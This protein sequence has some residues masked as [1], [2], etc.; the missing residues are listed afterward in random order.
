MLI[1]LGL[2]TTIALFARGPAAGRLRNAGVPAWL[3][4][5]RVSGRGLPISAA[6]KA[7]ALALAV[8]L[9]QPGPSGTL[10][11]LSSAAAAPPP[12]AE[13]CRPGAG[14]CPPAVV[15]PSQFGYYATN[16]RKWPGPV[17]VPVSV[18]NGATPALP[19]KSMIPGVDQES[20]PQTQPPAGG[21]V[22]GPAPVA[23]PQVIRLPEP[24]AAA[25]QGPAAPAAEAARGPSQEQRQEYT[26]ESV[27]GP[28]S[29][30]S[31]VSPRPAAEQP[32][33]GPVAR[34]APP[35]DAPPA[36][37]T[38]SPTAPPATAGIVPGPLPAPL[39]GPVPRQIPIVTPPAASASTGTEPAKAD[40]YASLPMVVMPG[41]SPALEKPVA[42]PAASVSTGFAAAW[43]DAQ[44]RIAEGKAADALQRLS[45]WRDD[46]TLDAEQRQRLDRQLQRLAGTVIYSQQDLLLPPHVVVPDET[47]PQI[48]GKLGVSWQFLAR[49]N[50]ITDPMRLIPGESIKIVRGPFD[51]VLSLSRGRLSLQL[52]GSYAGEFPV[53]VGSRFES[54]VG[55]VLPVVEVRRGGAA[56]TPT[57]RPARG[58]VLAEDLVI[59][60]GETTGPASAGQSGSLIVSSRDL[61]ELIDILG[62]GSMVLVRP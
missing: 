55:R 2:I 35:A 34:P 32:A 51:A 28:A 18:R 6:T 11:L 42:P 14:G 62:P 3:R 49:I 23:P 21:G 25:A 27:G 24:P 44:D 47:L 57:A 9:V 45:A 46:P 4:A 41:V 1:I 7:V 12:P 59:E 58:L 33:P 16:W 48:A 29:D 17:A 19:P 36:A 56:A 37:P 53:V 26:Q 22:P 52:R 39:R 8:A 50:G 20:S 40:R 61:D 15:R 38:P 43:A 5:A 30:A 10:A 31:P 60:A 54:S 13:N